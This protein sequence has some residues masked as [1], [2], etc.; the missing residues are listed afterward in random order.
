[1]L[2]FRIVINLMVR[3]KDQLVLGNSLQILFSDELF[4]VKSVLQS[5]IMYFMSIGSVNNC[6]VS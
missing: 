4:F 2:S 6:V 1:M 5:I 3:I